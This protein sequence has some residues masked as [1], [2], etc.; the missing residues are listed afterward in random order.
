[1]GKVKDKMDL[2]EFPVFKNISGE[3]RELEPTTTVQPC[4]RCKLD[5]DT[6]YLYWDGKCGVCTLWDR[7]QLRQFESKVF[8][9]LL[10]LAFRRN[11]GTV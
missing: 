4:T 6:R 8:A 10:W 11:Y 5:T 1:M 9:N 2:S 7:Q 3:L